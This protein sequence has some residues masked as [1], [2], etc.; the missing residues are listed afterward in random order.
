MQI[1]RK[2][3]LDV[4]KGV[5]VHQVNCMNRIGGGLSGSI[6]RKW[7]IVKEMYHDMFVGRDLDNVRKNIFKTWQPVRVS[8]DLIVIN[9]FTQFGYGNPRI[10]HEKYTDED[11]LVN[12]LKKICLD[13]YP[14]SEVWIPYNIGCGLGG[15]K[16]EELEPRIR[17]LPLFVAKL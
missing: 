3:L 16:W 2:N 15:A 4:T 1:V 7:P 17:H 10:T 13:Y 8:P 5:I 6:I 9:C 11:A 12:A 14:G